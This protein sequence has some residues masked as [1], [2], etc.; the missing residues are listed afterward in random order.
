MLN[1]RASQLVRVTNL[2]YNSS[3]EQ[4][5]MG[6][7]PFVVLDDPYTDGPVDSA[8]AD[9]TTSSRMLLAQHMARPSVGGRA[10]C[11]YGGR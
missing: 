9:S 8:G 1:K 5:A 11:I 3:V 4:G 2:W 7:S 10:I 6:M